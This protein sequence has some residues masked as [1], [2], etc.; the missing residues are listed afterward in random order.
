MRNY[1]I[2]ICLYFCYPAL[3]TSADVIKDLTTLMGDNPLFFIR[4]KRLT[5]NLFFPLRKENAFFKNLFLPQTLK[6]FQI[7]SSIPIKANLRK[8]LVPSGEKENC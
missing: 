8:T 6:K 7:F 2:I 5:R 1:L 3:W 4:G